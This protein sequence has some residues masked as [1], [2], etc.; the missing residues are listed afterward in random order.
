MGSSRGEYDV[1]L[2]LEMPDDGQCC[3][4]GGCGCRRRGATVDQDYATR[5]CRRRSRDSKEGG[6]VRLQTGNRG[7]SGNPIAVRRFSRCLFEGHGNRTSMPLVLKSASARPNWFSSSRLFSRGFP[8]PSR[9]LP[10]I[11]SGLSIDAW[12]APAIRYC[13]SCRPFSASVH[14]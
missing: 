14:P 13:A 11:P 8:Q 4:P 9:F 2:I 6:I 10:S 12:N 7:G 1:V 3:V 5:Y